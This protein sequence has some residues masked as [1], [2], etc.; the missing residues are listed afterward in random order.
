MKGRSYMRISIRVLSALSA[1]F[2]G[3]ILSS[4]GSD[5]KQI[6]NEYKQITV[7]EA[8]RIM[9]EESGFVILD[10]RRQDEY[11]SGHIPGAFLLTNESIG[12]GEI[13]ALPDKSQKILVY[14]RSGNRSKQAANKLA[15]LGYTNVYEFGGIN[16]WPYEI[17]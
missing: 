6:K 8:K 16:D 17:E 5:G 14:C 9:D 1:L 10:V 13:P 12:S 2:M 7:E 11:D 4:C 15:D 3:T